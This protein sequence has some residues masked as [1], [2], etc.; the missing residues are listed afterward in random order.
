LDF[1]LIS[2]LL[3]G[4]LAV[5]AIGL[6]EAVS[7]ARTI[8]SQTGQRLDS[9]Q[10]FIGQG[11]ANI[12]C[13]FLSGYTSSG[14]FTRS[15]VN[16]NAGA[17]TAL[18]SVFGCIM[19]LIAMLFL[20]PLAAYV[21]LP[22]LAGVLILTAIGLIDYKEIARIWQSGRGDRLIMI[23]TIVA[24]LALPLQF[25]VMTGITLSLIHYLVRTST[26]RVHTVLPDE[27]FR[28]FV[29]QP[30]KPSC[31]QLGII[32]VLG[33]LYFGATS[34]I[35]DS[36]QEN[37]QH[38][39]DQRF[40]LLRFHSVEHCDISGIHTLESIVH[41]YRERH[42]DVYLT[43]VQK[44]VI[45]LMQAS[46]FYDY[47]GADHFL[48]PDDAIERLF[49]R[50][51][52]PAVCIYECPVRAFQECQNLPKYRY[53][54]A[55]RLDV[56]FAPDRVPAVTAQALWATIHDEKPPQVID[57]REPREYKGG[58]IPNAH[59]IP[60]PVLLNHLD[61]IPRDHP[62]VMVCQSGRRSTRATALLRDRG[63]DNV[64][65]LEGGMIAWEN[66]QLLEAIEGFG[67]EK[68]EPTSIT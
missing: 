50:V 67:G 13:A 56:D 51:I 40:L 8:A 59:S 5:A 60:L 19:L 68:D 35:E 45:E 55:V 41:A 14:S 2:K 24:T 48:A 37:L 23:V 64:R 30:T 17:K 26:P 28:H 63:Y 10:E 39:P 7:I 42:G 57:V 54:S 61:Q 4:S 46:G 36:I 34:H 58:H 18:S 38:N 16:H 21:P 27:Q 31:P 53:P 62:V 12:A 9:N 20:A 47:Q 65:V 15:A 6:V 66:E 52:D 43:R 11:L 32:E 33:D 49:Y 29:H 3:A 25:A 44:T 22:A 1:D